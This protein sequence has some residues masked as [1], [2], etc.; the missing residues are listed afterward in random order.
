MCFNSRKPPLAVF[1]D[2]QIEAQTA[3]SLCLPT[4]IAFVAKD[5]DACARLTVGLMSSRFQKRPL[6]FFA[7]IITVWKSIENIHDYWKI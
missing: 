6:L 7:F 3:A 1:L 4:P 2:I 5:A